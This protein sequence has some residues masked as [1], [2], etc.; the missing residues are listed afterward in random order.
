MDAENID[1]LEAVIGAEASGLRIVLDLK[2]PH[3][4][5]SRRRQFFLYAAKRT[6]SS[7]RIAR[8]ISAKWM[9]KRAG[10]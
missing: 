2:R 7:S 10:K 4:S 6:A 5:G 9:D 3:A 1:E 8:P